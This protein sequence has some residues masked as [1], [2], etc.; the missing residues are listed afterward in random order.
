MVSA[1]ITSGNFPTPYLALR[2]GVDQE[3]VSAFAD[4]QADAARML[5]WRLQMDVTPDATARERCAAV[6]ATYERALA[7]RYALARRG[8]IVGGVGNVGAD[9]ERFRTPIT[10][11]SPNLD[12]IGRV[13][14]FYEGARWDAETLTYVGGV[15]TRAARITEAYGRAAL[16]RFAAECPG[17]EV[18]DNVVTLPDGARVTGN[19]LIRGE[20]ARR[21]GAELA[22]R[23]TARG[24]DASRMEI[25]GDPIYV[26]TATSRD[27]AVIREAALRLLATAE[28]GDEQAWW[29]ASYLLHQA[30][31]YKKG[32]DAVTRVFRVAVGAWLLGYAPTLDQDTDLRCMVLGQTAATTL[33]HVC[34]GA[35]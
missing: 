6:A 32:S 34:G 30:P 11:D 13:G 29:Q 17:G 7:W 27:R 24:L 19:R 2:A 22:E 1:R 28:P 26:V 3:Q 10:D 33:P 31:T 8:A 20:T 18:L 15:D 16:A 25:G 5:F 4:E 14:R 21:A 35:A 9:A 12:R 23:V